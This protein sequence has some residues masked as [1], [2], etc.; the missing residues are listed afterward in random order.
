MGF[1]RAP[2]LQCRVGAFGI[3]LANNGECR[4]ADL[5][6]HRCIGFRRNGSIFPGKLHRAVQKLIG[7][8]ELVQNTPCNRLSGVDILTALKNQAGNVRRHFLAGDFKRADWEIHPNPHF[9]MS[10]VDP[11]LLLAAGQVMSAAPDRKLKQSE[12]E[13]IDNLIVDRSMDIPCPWICGRNG[14]HHTCADTPEGLDAKTL[15]LVARMS[16]AY[17]Y[18]IASADS[19]R[20]SQFADLTALHAEHALAAEAESEVERMKEAGLDDSL[21][22]LRYLTDRHVEAVASAFKLLSPAEQ[23]RLR[24]HVEARQREVRRVGEREVERLARRAGKPG[25]EPPVPYAQTGPLA[26][27]RPRRLGFGPVSLDRLSEEE[28]EGHPNTRW[29]GGL[30]RTLNWCDGEHTLAEAAYLAA[31]D[32]RSR[33]RR[34]R[35]GESPAATQTPDELMRRI[36]W[37][38]A[39]MFEYFQFLRRRGYVTW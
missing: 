39:S 28:R 3:G 24:P 33:P 11:L 19:A 15:G 23:S 9:Q 17:L 37:R 22:Y 16:A 26:S 12:F 25:H 36:D 7:V 20:A 21:S 2:P 6:F 35:W 5:F 30:F 14:T 1:I 4:R 10:Y 13:L 34:T 8:C 18:L 29:T 38:G 32:L 31:S 27:I